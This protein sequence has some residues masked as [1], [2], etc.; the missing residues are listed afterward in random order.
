[1]EK[2]VGVRHTRK[3]AQGTQK[4][5]ETTSFQIKIGG[6]VGQNFVVTVSG[7]KQGCPLSPLLFG[8]FIEELHEFLKVECSGINVIDISEEALRELIYADDVAMLALSPQDLQKLSKALE[9]FSGAIFMDVNCEKTEMMMFQPSNYRVNAQQGRVLYGTCDIVQKSEFK[10]LGLWL[11]EK[12]WFYC[13][14][15]KLLETATKAMW[16]VIAR[17][18]GLG[19]ICLKAKLALL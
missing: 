8:L 19:I 17:C 15:A 18:E 4:I 13:A 11:H 14:P 16:A 5:Y 12:T 6:K 10:Y 7:V 1:M 3:Y 2:T 9:K